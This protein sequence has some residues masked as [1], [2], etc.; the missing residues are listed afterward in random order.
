MNQKGRLTMAEHKT[1][2]TRW[3]HLL[4]AFR[5]FALLNMLFFHF[6][7]DVYVIFSLDSDWYHYPAVRVWQQFI[8]MSFLI[9]SGMS[10]HFSRNNLKRG[11][12]L[13]IYGLLITAVTGLVMPDQTVRF[14]ILNCIGCCTLL[15]I[16]L[17][18]ICILRFDHHYTEHSPDKRVFHLLKAFCGLFP[19]LLLF[20]F[21]RNISDGYFS[22]AELHIDLPDWLYSFHPM[23]IL[24]FPYSGFRS[25]DYFPILPWFF[26]FLSGYWLWEVIR[27]SNRAMRALCTKVPV[28]SRLGQKTIW[29][30]LLHQPLL[31]GMAYLLITV[32]QIRM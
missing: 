23:T 3:Y 32:F 14:G 11:I 29:I 12:Q 7:Y 13:N 24:G 1:E 27:C 5:G 31:Y 22:L 8:C 4:D 16:P 25:S 30:Y 18:K 17:N 6:Y 9:V 20:L 21:T 15:M 10:W 19:A 28:L 2:H 26:L